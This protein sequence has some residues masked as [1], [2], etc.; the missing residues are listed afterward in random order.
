MKALS[1]LP[2]NSSTIQNGDQKAVAAARADITTALQSD[3]PHLDMIKATGKSYMTA[4]SPW[5]FTHF[6]Q[7]SF[8]K[9]YIFLMDGSAFTSRWQQILG[10]RDQTDIIEIVAWNDY[11]ESNYVNA[12]RGDVPV[13]PIIPP[14]FI[15]VNGV[16][17]SCVA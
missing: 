7:Q 3:P 11:G 8:K 9:N 10:F 2:V 4:V 5:F 6:S 15:T 13:C 1:D 17:A 14:V 16:F 12:I